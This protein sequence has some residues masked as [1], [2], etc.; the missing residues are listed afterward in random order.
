MVEQILPNNFSPKIFES[1]RSLKLNLVLEGIPPHVWREYTA[2]K[3]LAPHCWIHSVQPESATGED[4]SAYRLSASEEED[5][6]SVATP[7]GE[8]SP[9]GELPSRNARIWMVPRQRRQRSMSTRSTTSDEPKSTVGRSKATACP[10]AAEADPIMYPLYH[11][12]FEV[13]R[14]S[15]ASIT[16]E[17]FEDPML[18]EAAAM[19][20]GSHLQCCITP[21]SPKSPPGFHR[22]A[23]TGRGTSNP[24]GRYDFCNRH[25]HQSSLMTSPDQ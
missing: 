21:T 4:L 15:P 24:T 22:T 10:P 2:A 17:T 14:F 3:I 5:I 18:L 23:P 9:R 1:E 7:S 12:E 11:E 20:M 8:Q 16:G 13:E 19:A 6:I 25:Q